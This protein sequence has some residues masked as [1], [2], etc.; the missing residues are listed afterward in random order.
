M[1]EEFKMKWQHYYLYNKEWCRQGQAIMNTLKEFGYGLYL[2]IKGTE[3]DC[4][5]NDNKIAIVIEKAKEW[6][7]NA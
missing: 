2:Q 1:Y 4:Y 5:Y 3:N 7:G 6:F